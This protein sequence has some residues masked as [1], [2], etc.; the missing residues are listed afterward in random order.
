MSMPNQLP[1]PITA[2]ILAGGRGARL[3]GGDKGLVRVAG[4]PLVER[5]LAALQ[6]QVE[7]IIISANRSFD[8]YQRYGHRLIRDD[9]GEFDGPL[10]GMAAVLAAEDA[11][12]ILF[13]PVDAARLPDDLASRLYATARS[14][15]RPVFAHDGEHP[16]P[17]C[18]LLPKSLL[19]NLRA[20]LQ[21]GQRSPLDWL[22]QNEATSVRFERWPR[23]L[24]SL[25]TPEEL[26]LVEQ[27]LR[28]P[29]VSSAPLQDSRGRIK[30]KLRLSLT[31][32]CNF[33][34]P[35]CMPEKPVW[36][37][38]DSLLT[39]AE[40]SRLLKIFVADFGITHLR[41]TGG[42][43]LLRRD[44]EELISESSAL[45]EQG[46][47]RVSLTTNGYLLAA[48]AQALQS[49]GLDDLNVSLDALTPAVFATLSGGRKVA[50][51]LEGIEAAATIGLPVKLNTVV[52]RGT[53][54]QEVLPLARWA[55]AR[56]LPLRLIEFMPL[57]GRG[58]W[59]RERVFSER[60]IVEQLSQSFSVTT[61]PRS[62]D[63]ATYYL[64]DGHYPLGII[65]T[66]SNPFCSTCDRLRM[67]AEGMLYTCLFSE[68]G[69]S[70]RDR[71]RDGSSDAQIKA[72][73]RDA[74]WHKEAGYIEHQGYVER[75][76][77]M[78]GI[79]G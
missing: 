10:A 6:P 42:E 7:R 4:Q 54:E 22:L 65:P 39:R 27:E 52:M 67:S 51:V 36:L 8:E 41:L 68:K 60:E 55:M 30:R 72:L 11:E 44:L 45:R 70:L 43:P 9:S 1:L 5:V 17:V 35:Y 73:I 79:G 59:S 63:P 78:H 2:A 69:P 34:C 25:N 56:R 29:P 58:S 21:N 18:C 37:P 20:S 32:R 53:N 24:W 66:V 15:G 19:P 48:R 23:R 75:P 26:A 62:S 12:W 13:V 31:D 16:V 49:A 57:D 3:G 14:S 46:L 64:L 77:T 47:Q 28:V 76:V 61:L 33:R 74:V 71:L 40:L 50:P 38:K